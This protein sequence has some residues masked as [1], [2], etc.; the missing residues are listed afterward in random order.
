LT[1]TVLAWVSQ[2][3]YA[4]IFFLLVLG[5]V[6]LPVPDET[7]L[8]FTGYLIHKGALH[9]VAAAASAFFGSTCGITV[10][11]V[12]GRTLGLSILH[13]YGKHIHLTEDRL[14]RVHNWFERFGRWTLFIGYWV[15][16]VRHFTAVVAGSSWLEYPRFATAAYSG[17]LVWSLSFISLGYFLGD[18]W[19]RLLA[20]IHHH[21]VVASLVLAVLAVMVIFWRLRRN[22]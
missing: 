4:A 10:S 22:P 2:Y 21:V 12:L 9:P 8:T 13:R 16:G 5:I 3:G 20:E 18:Q 15:P 17:A 1:E 6:G 19:D 11:Y 14:A 7:L